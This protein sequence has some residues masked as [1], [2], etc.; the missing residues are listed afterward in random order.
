MWLSKR[1]VTHSWEPLQTLCKDNS[2]SDVD[3]NL[4]VW[5]TPNRHFYVS[6]KI[7]TTRSW[8]EMK[9]IKDPLV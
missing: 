4:D 1:V 3:R 2:I 7:V 9:K 6:N 5:G 8:D